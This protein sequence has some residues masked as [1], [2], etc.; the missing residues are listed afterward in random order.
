[1][2]K[3]VI[4]GA[5]IA[6]LS[7]LNAFLDKGYSP[8]LIEANKIGSPKLCGEF[9][10]PSVI[11]V[12]HNWE[13]NAIQKIKQATFFT[14][15]NNVNFTFDHHAGAI[16]RSDVELALAERAKQ[17]HARI[18]ENITIQHI[19]P[20]IKN[21]NHI[22]QLQSGTTIEAETLIVATGKYSNNIG[23]KKLRYY[24]IKTHI[25]TV[26]NP[27]SLWMFNNKNAYFG[28]IPVTNDISNCTCLIDIKRLP[29]D[30]SPK[31]YFFKLI[32]MQNQLRS[33]LQEINFA[34]LHYLEESVAD[35]NLKKPLPWENTYWIGDAL[36]SFYPAIGYGF[37][38]SI[39]SGCK[40]AEFYTQNN[41]KKYLHVVL[42]DIKFKRQI[43]KL[44]HFML[45]HSSLW[46]KLIF[47]LK[48]QTWLLNFILRKLNYKG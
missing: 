9:L 19:N 17:K 32:H 15:N 6:G 37:A 23:S 45:L 10:A 47:I 7:C 20:S 39:E 1:M 40:A 25:P 44:F 27:N 33:L 4:I 22:L 8:L 41:P 12:L 24:G 30:T 43:G 48:K 3:I 5:G 18:V 46:A 34:N 38:H 31:E 21:T 14:Q 11:S 13:I 42:L 2:E 29:E 28:L 26:V 36:A 35:F 16:K